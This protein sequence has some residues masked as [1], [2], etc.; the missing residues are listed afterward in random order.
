[1]RQALSVVVVGAVV[2]AG[3]GCDPEMNIP[4]SDITLLQVNSGDALQ[5]DVLNFGDDR[6]PNTEDDFIPEDEIRIVFHN[7]PSDVQ[8]PSSPVGAFSHVTFDRYRV[9]YFSNPPVDGYVGGMHAIVRSGE[10]TGVNVV[11]VPA[12]LKFRSP[13]FDLRSG[14]EVLSTALLEFWG[15]EKT[16]D[17]SVYVR[18]NVVI[19]FANFGDPD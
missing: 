9:T 11:A 3:V 1:M 13:L 12:E 8:G 17:D 6:I 15:V 7:T 18:G 19:N 16:S 4:R 14:G 2:L 10:T 5:S